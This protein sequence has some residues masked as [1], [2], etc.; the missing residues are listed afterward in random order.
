MLE[1]DK[2]EEQ[3][4]DNNK[5]RLNILLRSATSGVL[6]SHLYVVKIEDY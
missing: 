2:E 6:T 4:V 5:N 1:E 3:E